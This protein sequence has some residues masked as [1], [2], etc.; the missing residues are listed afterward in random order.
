M[1]WNICLLSL[2]LRIP[3]CYIAR[4]LGLGSHLVLFWVQCP[5]PMALFKCHLMGILA[6]APPLHSYDDGHLFSRIS[7]RRSEP[8]MLAAAACYKFVVEYQYLCS[9][10]MSAEWLG[11]RAIE[12][13]SGLRHRRHG[14]TRDSREP[15]RH[16]C[17]AT[18]QKQICYKRK[19]KNE[20]GI[21]D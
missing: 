14:A 7:H 17:A 19:H 18:T 3:T 15:N 2:H 11:R 4:L 10:V 21:G 16:E 8:S 1:S 9:A 5:P 13:V 12:S 20:S 6:L